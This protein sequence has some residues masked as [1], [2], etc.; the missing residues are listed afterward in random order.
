MAKKVFVGKI[1]SAKMQK[2]VTVLVDMV[3]VH[4]L[5]K[6]RVKHTSKFKA[7]L[8]GEIKVKEGDFVKIESC[9]PIS[10]DKK[11]QVKEVL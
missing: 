6:K 7:H 5:Y 8:P 11:W 2:T 3:K 9:R 4:P 1:K 10:K